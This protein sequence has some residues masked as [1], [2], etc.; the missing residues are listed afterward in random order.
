M[1]CWLNG[2][3]LFG[4]AFKKGGK[5]VRG[6]KVGGFWGEGKIGWPGVKR[7]VVPVGQGL[8]SFNLNKSHF[9]IG[10]FYNLPGVQGGMAGTGVG[11]NEKLGHKK[12]Q[13]L[14]ETRARGSP[15]G[16]R[17]K[18]CT[19]GGRKSGLE[20]GGHRGSRKKKLNAKTRG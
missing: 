15:T 6:E 14:L 3:G 2:W 5:E 9:K 16:P 1:M 19:A 8:L 13:I 7:G 20:P 4:G 11:K 17:A 12:R 10:G 18:S